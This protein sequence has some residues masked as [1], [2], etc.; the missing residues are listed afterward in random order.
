MRVDTTLVEHLVHPILSHK[1]KK[2]NLDANL[3]VEH[4]EL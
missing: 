4:Q 2:I 3:K 1:N